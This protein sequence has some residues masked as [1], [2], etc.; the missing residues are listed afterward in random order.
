MGFFTIKRLLYTALILL[1]LVIAEVEYLEINHTLGKR[2]ALQTAEHTLPAIENLILAAGHWA[3]ERAVTNAALHADEVN[4]TKRIRAIATQ[5]QQGDEALQ[6]ALNILKTAHFIKK[7]EITQRVEKAH[8][9]LVKT[10]RKVDAQ[11]KR[12]KNKR[13]KR[14]IK[15][16]MP[17]V[18]E[19]IVESQHMRSYASEEFVLADVHL[20]FY[21]NLM[22]NTWIMSE[23]AER[24]RAAL[25]G[26]INTQTA[27]SMDD[28]YALASNRGHLETGWE[29]AQ[30]LLIE[31][32]EPY[33]H[34]A[35]TKAKQVFFGEFE[36]TRDAVYTAGKKGAP[37]PIN[38]DAWV[39]RA[40]NGI[41]TIIALQEAAI[42]AAYEYEQNAQAKANWQFAFDLAL[43]AITLLV[44]LFALY[45]V[46][47]RFAK[48]I[49]ALTE[50]MGK[51]AE[52]NTEIDVPGIEKNDEM[53]VMAQSVQVFKANAIERKRL[54]KEQ[55][56]NEALATQEKIDSMNRL[57]DRFDAKVGDMIRGVASASEEMSATVKSMSQNA[58]ST[59]ENATS[60]ASASEETSQ[61]V[62]T[63]ASATEEMSASVSEIS[64]QVN[65]ASAV[66][67]VAAEEMD[68]TEEYVEALSLRADEIGGVVELIHDITEQINLL[69]L[70]ATIEAA[71]AGDMGKGFAVVATEVK[72]LAEQTA[73]ATE[74]ITEKVNE[75]QSSTKDVV[76]ATKSV[77]EVIDKIKGISTAVASAIEEQTATTQE[78]AS[79]VSQASIGTQQVSK[80]IAQ[81]AAQASETGSAAKEMLN[82]SSDLSKQAGA[83]QDQVA[84]FLKEVRTTE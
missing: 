9:A 75:M 23:Y 46:Q 45:V 11:L 28:M 40:T 44:L 47:Y 29:T 71:R 79:N 10:R 52:G 67:E 17:T 63:V 3:R 27:F 42:K 43:V 32:K 22:H 2:Q 25:A 66:T 81:V 65:S 39:E 70:N 35:V 19:I 77:G 74:Q 55:K 84:E 13:N 50:M 24:E 33:V 56:E 7:E 26:F 8:K 76:K 12:P 51:L 30:E 54:Y 15:S 36:K 72:N 78:I 59:E 82:V 57:A 58:Q 49:A 6:R 14:L 61:N 68:R 83:L 31:V 60:I 62:Q 5:R 80:D 1:G 34:D 21:A 41:D 53:G 69:A 37:Y 48:P 16:W 38:A 64:E 4:S 20:G 73:Q 18:T